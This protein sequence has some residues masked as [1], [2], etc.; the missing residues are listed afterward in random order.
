M[1]LTQNVRDK[2]ALRILKNKE[3]H[4]QISE[5]FGVSRQ[6]VTKIAQEYKIPRTPPKGK[7]GSYTYPPR[8]RADIRKVNDKFDIEYR[9][10]KVESELESINKII[11]I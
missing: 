1:K 3:T 7:V 11:E 6:L 2:I 4:K 9:L 10:L 8:S 5:I